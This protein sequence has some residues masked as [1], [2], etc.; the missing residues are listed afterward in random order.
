ML[1]GV[2]T[3]GRITAGQA[4]TLFFGAT[5]TRQCRYGWYYTI[6]LANIMMILVTNGDSHF[7]PMVDT[8]RRRCCDYLRSRRSR[9][10]GLG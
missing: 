7:I 3:I 1:F 2:V 4:G 10:A 8:R 9:H 6:A 5:A